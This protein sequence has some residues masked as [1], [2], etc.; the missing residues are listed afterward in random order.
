MLMAEE[1]PKKI[2]DNSFLLEEAYSQEKGVVQH[3]QSFMMHK[4]NAAFDAY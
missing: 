2:A 3:I 1:T 4:T